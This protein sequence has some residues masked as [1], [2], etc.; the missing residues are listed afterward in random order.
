MLIIFRYIHELGTY[1]VL[2][3]FLKMAFQV[4]DDCNIRRREPMHY[5]RLHM[6]AGVMWDNLGHFHKSIG[7]FTSCLNICQECLHEDDEFLGGT[8]NDLG[9]VSES[10]GLWKEAIEWHEKSWKIRAKTDDPTGENVAHSK[11]NKA[12]SLLMLD[13][14]EDA[15]QMMDDACDVFFAASAWFHE[16]Q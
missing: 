16:A 15:E 8:Y 1:D 10:L 14:D 3:S 11:S 4:F 7:E 2:E 6:V 9:N 13:H 12:R 5:A